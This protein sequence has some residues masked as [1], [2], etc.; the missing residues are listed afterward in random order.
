MPGQRRAISRTYGL[1]GRRPVETLNNIPVSQ[2]SSSSHNENAHL[3][4]HLNPK[5]ISDANPTEINP[6]WDQ[7]RLSTVKYPD[8]SRRNAQRNRSQEHLH[9]E[10]YNNTRHDCE[11]L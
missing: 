8:T 5:H 9:T 6:E 7:I 3:T 10:A 1:P 11:E 2:L 4:V